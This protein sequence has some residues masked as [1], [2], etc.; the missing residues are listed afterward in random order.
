MVPGAEYGPN[1]EKKKKILRSHSVGGGAPTF[2]RFTFTK[3]L[4]QSMSVCHEEG[5][6]DH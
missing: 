3:A 5:R 1:W 2:V 4:K 6:G